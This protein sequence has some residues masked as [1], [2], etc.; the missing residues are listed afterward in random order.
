MRNWT[1]ALA[2]L[3]GVSFVLPLGCES[4]HTHEH[5]HEHTHPYAE[6]HH[7]HYYEGLELRDVERDCKVTCQ[8]TWSV[9]DLDDVYWAFQNMDCDLNC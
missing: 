9:S 4:S 1:K 2:V 8:T 7:S 5:T 3:V 6:N